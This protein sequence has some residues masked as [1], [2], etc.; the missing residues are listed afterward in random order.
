MTVP[1][2]QFNSPPFEIVTPPLKLMVPEPVLMTPMSVTSPA[3]VRLCVVVVRLSSTVRVPA[4]ARS[5]PKLTGLAL[6]TIMLLYVTPGPG[7][8][9]TGLLVLLALASASVPLLF[10]NV[11]PEMLKS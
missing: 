9:V 3:T 10:E 6:F 7:V 5:P 4:T 2:S 11:P 8:N 1:T